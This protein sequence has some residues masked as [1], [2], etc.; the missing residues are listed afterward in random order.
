MHKE[1][2]A[3]EYLLFKSGISNYQISKET[4]I[5]PTVLGKY[6]NG[7]SNVENMTFGN[8]IK[9]YDCYLKLKEENKVGNVDR[10]LLFGRLLGVSNILGKMVFEKDKISIFDKYMQRFAKNPASTWA[11]IHADLM[12]YTHKF[13]TEENQLLHLFDEIMSELDLD[14]FNDKPLDGKYLLGFYK[15]QHQLNNKEETEQ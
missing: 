14:L 7:I 4:G 9:L 2:Q 13:G 15:Q 11:K 12:E 5:S 6:S 3:I 1:K 8:A 10:D